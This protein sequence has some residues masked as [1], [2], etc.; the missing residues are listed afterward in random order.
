MIRSLIVVICIFCVATILSEFVGLG[1]LWYR[2]QLTPEIIAEIRVILSGQYHDLSEGEQ[3]EETFYPSSEDI[4]KQRS[5]SIM[6]FNNREEELD[7]LKSL[8]DE[9]AVRF[10]NQQEI[11]ERNKIEF[12]KKLATLVEQIVSEGSEQARGVLV[13]L[14]SSDAVLYLMELDLQVNI[15]LL[16]GMPEKKIAEYQEEFLKGD[17]KQVKRG[18]EI[19]EALSRGEPKKSL[20]DQTQSQLTEENDPGVNQNGS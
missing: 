9:N 12:D 16:K 2:G 17:Q 18:H 6:D 14:T 13:K 5:I 4:V 11:F 10:S 15:V 20:I 7:S 8:V 19:F 1:F 3:E